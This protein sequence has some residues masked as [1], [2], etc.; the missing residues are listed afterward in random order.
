MTNSRGADVGCVICRTD[1][2][3]LHW[4]TTA[5]RHETTNAARSQH[6]IAGG[7]NRTVQGVTQ[8]CRAEP[9]ARRHLEPAP[10]TTFGSFPK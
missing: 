8:G 5:S 1:T 10:G 7:R 9:D 6:A 2:E 3:S 4:A